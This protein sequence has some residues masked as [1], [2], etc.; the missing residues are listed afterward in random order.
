MMVLM[1][2]DLP[3][4]VAPAISRCGIFSRSAMIGWPSRLR[5]S[6]IGSVARDR[7]HSAVSSSS[8]N[9][10]TLAVGLGTSTPTAALPGIGATIRI[11]GAR[12]ASA[13]SSANAAIRPTFTPGAGAT[14]YC[15]TTGPVVR[16]AIDPSTRK[17]WSVSISTSPRRSIS[18]SSSSCDSRSCSARRSSGGSSSGSPVTSGR[19]SPVDGASFASAPNGI[20]AGVSGSA[21]ADFALVLLDGR[22]RGALAGS[23]GAPPSAALS[24]PAASHRKGCQSSV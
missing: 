11:D 9:V 24:A 1:H 3:E 22:D 20:A 19:S 5:P 18:S 4:P 6:A 13:R 16:P 10:T 2:T 21:G 14:S 7:S 23:G 15:V 17:V 8:R 12:M